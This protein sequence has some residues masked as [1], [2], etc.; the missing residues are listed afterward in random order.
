[1]IRYD[2]IFFRNYPITYVC[3]YFPIAFNDND[4]EK[5]V[6]STAQRVNSERKA[7]TLSTVNSKRC[8]HMETIF[9]T[10][11]CTPAVVGPCV[12]KQIAA[13][14]NNHGCLAQ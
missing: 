1:M 10:H 6:S 4:L 11:K 8:D 12:K 2:L 3:T 14:C 7:S 13:F 5:L 9:E